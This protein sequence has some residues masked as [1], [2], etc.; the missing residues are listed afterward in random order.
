MVKI[1][2]RIKD[3]VAL[4]GLRVWEKA[5]CNEITLEEQEPNNFL[6]ELNN[7]KVKYNMQKDKATPLIKKLYSKIINK[8]LSKYI[9]DPKGYEVCFHE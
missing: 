7:P 2:I 4:L 8:S 6:V 3:Q 5:V 1:E 9:R